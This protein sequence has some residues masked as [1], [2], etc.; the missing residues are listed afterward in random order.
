MSHTFSIDEAGHTVT[1]VLRGDDAPDRQLS[2]I[3]ALD[4]LASIIAAHRARLTG[5]A[6]PAQPDPHAQIREDAARR[7]EDLNRELG[8]SLA[9]ADAMRMDRLDRRR[10]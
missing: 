9:N 3:E 6:A 7:M 1:A 5:D 2:P 8:S 10:P 4:V